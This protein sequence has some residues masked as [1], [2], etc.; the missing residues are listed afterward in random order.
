MTDDE[1]ERARKQISITDEFSELLLLR[2]A[3]QEEGRDRVIDAVMQRIRVPA[4]LAESE[5][6]LNEIGAT[7]RPA[8][9]L[10]IAAAAIVF[11][12]ARLTVNDQVSPIT[13]APSTARALGLNNALARWSDQRDR[14]PQLLEVAADLSSANRQR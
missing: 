6:L 7:A 10:G 11:A 2:P 9:A 8:L 12:V 3:G 13:S 14:A 5:T 4:E 1:R